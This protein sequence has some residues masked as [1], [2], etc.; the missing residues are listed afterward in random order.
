MPAKRILVLGAPKSGKLTLVKELTGSVPEIAEYVEQGSPQIKATS[1]VGEVDKLHSSTSGQEATDLRP[2]HAGLS[3]SLQLKTKYFE[4]DIPIWIDE[5]SEVDSAEDLKKDG[6]TEWLK[7]FSAEAASEVISVLG[8]VIVTFRKPETSFD[9]ENVR[10][11]VAQIA[12]TVH[13]VLKRHKKSVSK[14]TSVQ[15]TDEEEYDDLDDLVEMDT[16]CLAVAMAPR[17]SLEK[18]A[19]V[20]LDYD[21]WDT[22]LESYG[23]EF[24]DSEKQGRNDY[25]ELQG[26]PRIKEALETF[27]WSSSYPKPSIAGYE[28]FQEGDSEILSDDG[29]DEE[30]KEMRLEMAALHFAV[31]EDDENTED[32]NVISAATNDGDHIDDSNI[33]ELERI[34][35]KMKEI[36]EQG[37]GLS[38]DERKKL[39]DQVADELLRLL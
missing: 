38:F 29:F 15:Q 3:C 34:M 19:A 6:L 20:E 39:A 8:A 26:I 31:K 23:F 14:S 36:R 7:S 16:I 10:Q 5:F 4:C 22:L 12:E 25:G 35:R 2:S 21:E 30:L 18:N 1:I 9:L 11:N 24:I 27:N 33:E 17:R 37:E 32:K 28:A 13:T